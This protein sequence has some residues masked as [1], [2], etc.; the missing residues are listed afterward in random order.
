MLN[1]YTCLGDILWR[2]VCIDECLYASQSIDYRLIPILIL[3][4]YILIY[5][6]AYEI[7][8]FILIF[9]IDL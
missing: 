8:F 2:G 9:K 4:N 1:L 5:S 6:S 7:E 3:S